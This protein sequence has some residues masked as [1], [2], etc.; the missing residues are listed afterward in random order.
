MQ[1]LLDFLVAL[2]NRIQFR[3]MRRKID[4]LQAPAVSS[5][6]GTQQRAFVSWSIVQ[7][8]YQSGVMPQQPLQKPDY[9]LLIH[10]VVECCENFPS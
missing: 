10:S 6:E 8:Y 3:A 9:F 5:E 4:E 1:G 7:K 2:L